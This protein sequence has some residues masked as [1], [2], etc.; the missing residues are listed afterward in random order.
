MNR[1]L[2][3]VFLTL[4]PLATVQ[5]SDLLEDA[6]TSDVVKRGTEA[7]SDS[8]PGLL[9]N[10]LGIDKD[11]A[12]GGLGSLLSL[13]GEN[14]GAAD[15]D[16]LKGLVPGASGYIDK[17]KS[18]GAITGPLK[19][20]DGLNAAL[21]KLGISPDVAA[22]FVPTVTNYLGKL[23]GEDAAKLLQKALAAA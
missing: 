12:E 6:Q 13:A 3:L 21:A 17:A 22:K 20:L 7:M 5:T 2:L 9:Q 10:Q 14:L 1:L 15:F 4:P 19:N 16:K 8:L 11:Q 18:L 23:G